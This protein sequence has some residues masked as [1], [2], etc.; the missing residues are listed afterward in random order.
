MQIRRGRV[1]FLYFK[2]T[3]FKHQS[4]NAQ[5]SMTSKLIKIQLRVHRAKTI[6]C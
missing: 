6:Y 5:L 2:N 4:D 1:G 3:L